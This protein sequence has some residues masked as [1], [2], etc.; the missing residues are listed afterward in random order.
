MCQRSLDMLIIRPRCR[1]LHCLLHVQTKPGEGAGG[2]FAIVTLLRHVRITYGLLVGRGRF[3][4]A[5][6]DDDVFWHCA[7]ERW[8]LRGRVLQ[9]HPVTAMDTIFLGPALHDS[10]APLRLP[11]TCDTRV[12]QQHLRRRAVR[13]RPIPPYSAGTAAVAAAAA[14]AS[15]SR[16]VVALRHVFRSGY[17]RRQQAA[18]LWRAAAVARVILWV[19]RGVVRGIV[20][21][22]QHDALPAPKEEDDQHHTHAAQSHARVDSCCGHG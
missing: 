16:R 21:R 9:Q 14:A 6:I 20:A 19:C 5:V 7:A 12:R 4:V 1:D 15:D 18:V 3:A 22:G 8:R 11:R 13:R 10:P 17:G 2:K